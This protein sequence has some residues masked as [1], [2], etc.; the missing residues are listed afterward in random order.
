MSGTSMAAPMV[1][2][3]AALVYSCRTDLSLMDVRQAILASAKPMEE[4]AGKLTAGGILDAYGAITYGP[5][6]YTHLVSTTS[7]TP[8]AASSSGSSAMT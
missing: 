1:T 6:S 7:S 4:M 3:V 2:G 8:G 5:V